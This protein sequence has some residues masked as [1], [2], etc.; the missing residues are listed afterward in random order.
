MLLDS[1]LNL[2]AAKNVEMMMMIYARAY[3]SSINNNNAV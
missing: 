1:T 3:P 2:T